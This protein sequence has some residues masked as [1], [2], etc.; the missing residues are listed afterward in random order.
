[1][2]ELVDIWRQQNQNKEKFMLRKM[3]V[4]IQCHLDYFLISRQ[5]TCMNLTDKWTIVFTPET[6][7][8]AIFICLQSEKKKKKRARFLEI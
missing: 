7:H 1:M 4:K 3:S 6:D 5:S 8:S 2:Y